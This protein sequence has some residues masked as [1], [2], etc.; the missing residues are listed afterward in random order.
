MHLYENISS[1]G[2]VITDSCEL[3]WELNPDQPVLLNA[4]SSLQPLKFEF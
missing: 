1:S 4:D 3:P 2:T